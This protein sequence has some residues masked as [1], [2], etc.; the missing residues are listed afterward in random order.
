M[1]DDR[2]AEPRV[3]DIV[4]GL[5]HEL[6]GPRAHGAIRLDDAL[7]RDLGIGSLERVELLL[8]IEKELGVR[9]SDGVMEEASSPRDLVAAVIAAEPRRP[10]AHVASR[11]RLAPAEAAPASA[12]TLLE[13]L[14]WHV[15]AHPERV[16]RRARRGAGP[17]DH[18]WRAL[19]ARPS[20]GGG[21]ARAPRGARRPCRPD[22]PNGAGVLRRLR[23]RP[24]RGRGSGADLSSVPPRSDRGVRPAPGRHPRQRRG[25]GADHVSGGRAGGGPACAPG[26]ARCATSPSRPRSPRSALC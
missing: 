6:G 9:L 3:L 5:V 12:A 7:D 16:A 26:C 1:G 15:M 24:A 18:L 4:G 17:V 11:P 23:R 25:A 8:R 19:A 14:E 13:V 10:E 22:A 2:G 21:V 20:G